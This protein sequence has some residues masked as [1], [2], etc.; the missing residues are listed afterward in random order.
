MKIEFNWTDKTAPR[1]MSAEILVT[2][3]IKEES[4][5]VISRLLMDLSGRRIAAFPT[6]E[7][8]MDDIDF[9]EN[10][11]RHTIT[12][13]HSETDYELK[14][15]GT[16]DECVERIER[17]MEY[18]IASTDFSRDTNYT[19]MNAIVEELKKAGLY[20]EFA[21]PGFY[22][23]YLPHK[24]HTTVIT[25][26]RFDIIAYVNYGSEGTWVNCY[27]DGEFDDSSRSKI[28]MGTFKTLHEDLNASLVMGKLAGAITFMGSMYVNK[29][30]ERFM[31][32]GERAK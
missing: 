2:E 15:Y 1:Y 22:E 14:E 12:F 24:F 31:P 9:S 28:D 10:H 30:I 5:R 26:Y 19:L 29:N 32:E 3:S 27:L 18:Y 21:A 11:V 17:W 4:A 6:G 20:D 8:I 25:D 23:Y 16:R 7:N 13:L